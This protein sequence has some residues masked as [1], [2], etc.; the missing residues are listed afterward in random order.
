MAKKNDSDPGSESF[1]YDPNAPDT[2]A[3]GDVGAK[4]PE[5]I[6][7]ELWAANRDYM[8]EIQD[9]FFPVDVQQQTDTAYANYL[10]GVQR[11]L[12]PDDMRQRLEEAFRRYV[13][14]IQDTWAQSDLEAMD[15]ASL[16]LIGQ[17]LISAGWTAASLG[18]RTSRLGWNPY[19]PWPWCF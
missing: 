6:V 16:A 7:A 2:G 5:D 15:A 12:S 11:A 14:R 17:S 13:R 9:A 19:S 4:R 3:R 10:R 18:I 1:T 8:R